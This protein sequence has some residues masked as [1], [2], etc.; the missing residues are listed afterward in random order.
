MSK[1]NQ[2]IRVERINDVQSS[3]NYIDDDY[4][5]EGS[6][7]TLVRVVLGLLILVVGIFVLFSICSYFSSWK[8]DYAILHDLQVLDRPIDNEIQNC[9]G[10]FGAVTGD[11]LVSKS[12]GIASLFIPLILIIFG[13]KIMRSFRNA[14]F[15]GA[16]PMIISMILLSVTLALLTQGDLFHS[17][18][19][20][21]WGNIS[22]VFLVRY[23][24]IPGAWLSVTFMWLILLVVVNRRF[25]LLITSSSKKVEDAVGN[26]PMQFP[27][28]NNNDEA[29]V[30]PDSETISSSEETVEPVA[31]ANPADETTGEEDETQVEETPE[32]EEEVI[33]VKIHQDAEVSEKEIKHRPYNPDS[34]PNYKFP[35]IDCLE[36]Y[37]SD[38]VVTDDEIRENREQISKVLLNFGVPIKEM[39]ATVGPTVTLYEIVQADGV[40]ISKIIGLQADITQALKASGV[41]IIA[42]MPGR[43]TIG[44]EVPNKKRQVVS[45]RSCVLSE[46]FQKMKA[47][48]PVVIGK[49]ISNENYVFDL[50]KMPHLIVAGATGQGKSVGLNAIISSL[51]YRKDP[52]QL[53]FVLVDPKQVEFSVYANIEN[54]FLA[55]MES[56]DGAVIS[57]A[58]KAVLTLNSLCLEMENRLTKC[59]EARVRNIEEYND[60]VRRR[61]VDQEE[62]MPYI[63]VIIDEFADLILADKGV[64]QPVMRL[65]AKARAIGIHLIVATQRPDVKVIT[66][67]IKANF[68]SRIA[69]KVAQMVDSKTIIDQPGAQCLTGKGDM[70]IMINGELERIQCAL[71]DTKEIN[72][73]IEFVSR[74][75]SPNGHAYLLP[76]YYDKGSE[77]AEMGSEFSE[78]PKNYDKLF[79]DIARDAV[80]SG[81]MSTSYIQRNYE[82]GFNRAGRIVEQLFKA[83]ILGPSRGSKPREV[84]FHDLPSLEAKLQE[85]GVF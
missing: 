21:D 24:G 72:S 80:S 31:V 51:L 27:A 76:D 10:Q 82:V 36:D 8:A 46:R 55:K 78:A 77:E 16:I 37:H 35:S 73:I 34:T 2:N 23:L 4:K 62:I 13:I 69:F 15:L 79:A 28:R 56:E 14:M 18:P 33:K 64:E 53:K 41:R 45:M 7:F 26:I 75:P 54:Q 61:E 67:T 29:A 65:A 63:V 60:L 39:T 74:Q 38:A 5:N 48:L 44:I 58:K 32:P 30:S 3:S 49:N 59:S 71:V 12:L 9:C 42:P 19:G 17:G 83:G 20:G 40:K 43:G 47:E 11:T 52:S 68:P 50:A 70:L 25:L 84:K 85:L 22:E 66:G 81:T 1:E 6:I 57:D